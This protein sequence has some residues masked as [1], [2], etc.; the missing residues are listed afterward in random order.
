MTRDQLRFL[1]S[2]SG[3]E[4]VEAAKELGAD[5]L[6]AVTALR[7]RW[8]RDEAAAVLELVALRRRAAG[9]F[10]RAD[11][12]FFDREALEQA[13]GER[14]AR[15]RAR[16]FA[17]RQIVADL[18]CGIG[19]DTIALAAPARVVAVDADRMRLL[20]L[21]E[22]ARVYSVADRVQ[23]ICGWVPEA[24]PA[25]TAAFA[26]PSRRVGEHGARR[27]TR[28]LAAMSPP[29]EALL[30]L[31][32]RIPDMGI[33]LS[34]AVDN[35]E[36][37]AALRGRPYELEF[38]SDGGEC[39]EA[40]LWLGEFVTGARRA[41]VLPAAQTKRVSVAEDEP[42][43]R[44]SQARVGAV[45]YEPDPAIIRAGMIAAVA[46]ELDGWTLDPQIAYLSSNRLCSS[47]FVTAYVV[48]ES[49][50][51]QLRR[52]RQALAAGGYRDVVVK[53]RGFPMEPE[54]LRR[55]LLPHLGRG[56]NGVATVIV[57]RV[58]KGHLAII[59]E[60][61]DGMEQEEL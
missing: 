22:N 38:I 44:P 6:A 42:A 19:G 18:C 39:R 21:R 34:P 61:A 31:T 9:R 4:A 8:Q 7:R 1:C 54:A 27:R 56:S 51:F 14:I 41:S 48:R 35:Q 17:G 53:K 29:L 25:V 47:P 40:V 58:G 52:L 45:L 55:Q 36:L 32:S 50:P 5:P 30:A 57:T 12:M 60:R 2:P 20:L 10:S 24:A 23:P 59:S 26:D 3:A 46:E 33:K 15:W 28:S 37:T 11:S 43:A 13:S 16:R 49:M